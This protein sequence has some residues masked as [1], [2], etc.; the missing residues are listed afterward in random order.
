MRRHCVWCCGEVVWSLRLS[1]RTSSNQS[2][3]ARGVPK[4][5]EIDKESLVNDT[6][7]S[8]IGADEAKPSIVGR[9]EVESE[10]SLMRGLA[11]TGSCAGKAAT[12]V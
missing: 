7:G 1:T 2:R 6:R 4:F 5:Q 9:Y 8:F 11:S 3:R 12:E 10:L